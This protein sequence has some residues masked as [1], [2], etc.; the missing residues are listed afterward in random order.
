M[1][2]EKFA[3]AD[4]NTPDDIDVVVPI[5]LLKELEKARL[6]LYEL[7]ESFEPP[8]TKCDEVN[9]LMRLNHITYPMYMLTHQKFYKVID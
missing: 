7:L 4:K 1:I 6:D 2:D 8:T 5:S 3:A 9:T